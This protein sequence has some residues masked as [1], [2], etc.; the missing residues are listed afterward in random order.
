[1]F[2]NFDPC[3]WIVIIMMPLF[4][5]Y[6]LKVKKWQ[7]EMKKEMNQIER[8]NGKEKQAIAELQKQ[9]LELKE[10]LTKKENKKS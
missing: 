9:V 2:Q 8:V 10:L 3:C 5:G 6:S 4:L 7:I 1:M